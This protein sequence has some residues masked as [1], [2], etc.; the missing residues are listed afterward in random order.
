MS[1]NVDKIIIAEIPDPQ[2]DPNLFKVIAKNMINGPF[3]IININ[4]TS[5]CMK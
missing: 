2:G 4:P 1:S 3:G 5:P